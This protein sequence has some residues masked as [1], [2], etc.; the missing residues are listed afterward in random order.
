MLAGIRIFTG[1]L[2]DYL[3]LG[4]LG[5][6]KAD[7]LVSWFHGVVRVRIMLVVLRPCF[8]GRLV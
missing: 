6:A 3:C 8:A 2:K 4:V 7:I 5:L 1:T